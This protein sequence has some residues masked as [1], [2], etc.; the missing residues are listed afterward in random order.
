MR[1]S[2]ANFSENPLSWRG[3]FTRLSYLAWGNLTALLFLLVA[4]AN[5]LYIIYSPNLGTTPLSSL[6][7]LKLMIPTLIA[8]VL[9]GYSSIVFTIRRLHDL[10]LS[11]WLFLLLYVPVFGSLFWLY[12]AIA[13]GTEGR[14]N[15]GFPRDTLLWEGLFGILTVVILLATF[16]FIVGYV[17]LHPT[18]EN[19]AILKRTF[20]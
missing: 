6:L 8:A 18:A 9:L 17:L 1:Y 2:R 11:G 4:F 15:H 20:K 10:N 7:V 3:R 19:L 5:I 12:T 13:K 14:N 16:S